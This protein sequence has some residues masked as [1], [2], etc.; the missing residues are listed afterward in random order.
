MDLIL[1]LLKMFGHYPTLIFVSRLDMMI[2]LST[3]S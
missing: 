1:K 2:H 3:Y